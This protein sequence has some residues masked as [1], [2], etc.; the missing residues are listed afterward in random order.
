MILMKKVLFSIFLLG[1]CAIAGSA[2]AHPRGEENDE[3]LDTL[4]ERNRRLTKR[5]NELELRATELEEATAHQTFGIGMGMGMPS[6]W[7]YSP[8]FALEANLRYLFGYYYQG[9]GGGLGVNT[10]LE[11][12][13]LK[14]RWLG[15]GVFWGDG[16]EFSVAQVNRGWDIMLRSALDIRVWRG[17]ELRAEVQWFFPN[18]GAVFRHAREEAR[19]GYEEGDSAREIGRTSW[20]TLRQSYRDV[21]WTPVA[22]LGVRWE[23]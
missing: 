4:E 18:P 9:A 1:V 15:A 2:F 10:L 23:F 12:W 6:D 21:L 22:Y 11:V 13:R 16:E 3:R 8:H 17:A 5:V 7:R 14:F 19:D 20:S